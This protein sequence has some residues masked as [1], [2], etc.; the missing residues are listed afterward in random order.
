MALCRPPF[1]LATGRASWDRKCPGK[2]IMCPTELVGCLLHLQRDGGTGVPEDED[3]GRDWAVQP[4]IHRQA[5]EG[6]LCGQI[7]QAV[8]GKHPPA[9]TVHFPGEDPLE[10]VIPAN[11]FEVEIP[12]VVVESFKLHDSRQKGPHSAHVGGGGDGGGSKGG[13]EG[14]GGDDGGEGGGGDGGG[15]D[16]AGGSGSRAHRHPTP[17]PRRHQHALAG[18]SCARVTSTPKGPGVIWEQDLQECLRK[19]GLWQC[20]QKGGRS[21]NSDLQTPG[22]IRTKTQRVRALFKGTFTETANRHSANMDCTSIA[23]RPDCIAKVLSYMG[24][25]ASQARGHNTKCVALRDFVCFAWEQCTLRTAGSD[26]LYKQSC[27]LIREMQEELRVRMRQ[28][29]GRAKDKVAFAGLHGMLELRPA[30]PSKHDCT[31]VMQQISRHIRAV[32]TKWSRSKQRLLNLERDED[33][34]IVRELFYVLAASVNPQ[35]SGT[36]AALILL[37]EGEQPNLLHGSL[38]QGPSNEERERELVRNVQG[39]NDEKLHFCWYCPANCTW[40]VTMERTHG[41][42]CDPG[43]KIDP[44]VAELL[45]SWRPHLERWWARHEASLGRKAPQAHY[46]FPT[47]KGTPITAQSCQHHCGKRWGVTW[48]VNQ[49]RHLAA[50]HGLRYHSAALVA[51]EAGRSN[52]ST[53]VWKRA[54]GAKVQN[55]PN[56]KHHSA[57]VQNWYDK[58]GK[59]LDAAHY[60]VPVRAADGSQSI[61]V[62]AVARLIHL[63]GST[64]DGMGLFAVMNVGPGGCYHLPPLRSDP[65]SPQRY[66]FLEMPLELA[67]P[68]QGTTNDLCWSSV[69]SGWVSRS[70]G[71]GLARACEDH[72]K[73]VQAW[74]EKQLADMAEE[75]AAEG[76][77]QAEVL[78]KGLGSAS[79]KQPSRAAKRCTRCW[80]DVTGPSAAPGAGP[81]VSPAHQVPLEEPAWMEVAIECLARAQKNGVKH[82]CRCLRAGQFVTHC[83]VVCEVAVSQTADTSIITRQNESVCLRSLEPAQDSSA[84][85]GEGQGTRWIMPG[86]YA[87]TF[88]APMKDVARPVDWTTEMTTHLEK[89]LRAI[90]VLNDGRPHIPPM[91]A[92]CC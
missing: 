43:L 56:L 13:G 15:G 88:S 29:E 62:C 35:R 83:G 40:W 12:Q 2:W 16:R 4:H 76:I 84:L 59:A 47:S 82:A 22:H 23:T 54:Y 34:G 3:K 24:A 61:L 87:G 17:H 36:W 28:E 63:N 65:S 64:T 45:T 30:D 72:R 67:L 91:D 11:E 21:R 68:L 31:I 42:Y 52:A 53:A 70:T 20:K 81:A 41:G 71:S 58:Q 69:H 85:G 89:P 9:W 78:S 8:H 26:Q 55:D 57:V 48:R 75:E 50:C 66:S 49:M 90:V 7:K 79:R 51:D 92:M 6:R 77:P 18:R 86:E 80:V 32:F 14:G 27:N 38:G 33:R 46:M 19:F 73:Q 37:P 5:H 10:E 74:C 25:A 39:K 44:S 60:V 1:T